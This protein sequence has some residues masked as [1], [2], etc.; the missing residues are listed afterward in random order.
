MKKCQKILKIQKNK[1]DELIE[2]I[3]SLEQA[4]EYDHEKI[5]EIFEAMDKFSEEFL[6]QKHTIDFLTPYIEKVEVQQFP[7]NQSVPHDFALETLE[8]KI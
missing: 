1:I 6:V 2:K 7:N 3:D 8:K 5:L 4:L